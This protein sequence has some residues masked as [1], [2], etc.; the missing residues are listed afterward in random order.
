M[1]HILK[2]L[3]EYLAC[4]DRPAFLFSFQF[5]LDIVGIEKNVL[6]TGKQLPG[7]R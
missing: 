7:K 6:C 2:P 3:K 5:I 1:K 4:C